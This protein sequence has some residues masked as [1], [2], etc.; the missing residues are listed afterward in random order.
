MKK[1]E[2]REI[3][4]ILFSFLVGALV[5]YLLL[6]ITSNINSSNII[7]DKSSIKVYEKTSL[8]SSLEKIYDAVVLIQALNGEEIKSNGSGFIYKVDDKYGYILTN[9]HILDTDKVRITFSDDE[10]TEATILGKDEYIDLAVLRIPK[11]YVKL[12]ATLGKSAEM[13]I[14]DAIYAVGSPLG[15]EYRGSVTSGILSG[16]NRMVST[17]ISSKKNN[18]WVMKVLQIDAS[19]N[20]GNS[21]GPILNINGE[22]IGICLMKLIEEDIE[23]MAFAIPIEDALNNIDD[24]EKGTKIKRPKLGINMVNTDNSGS[25]LN[26]DIELPK[27]DITGV[28]ITEIEKDTSAANSGLKKGDIITK[29]DDIEIKDVGYL[30]YEL[31]NHK[32]GD[33]INITYIRDNNVHQTKIKLQ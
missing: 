26:H 20:P 9:E 32:I 1:T 11:K 18:D 12:V 3:K 27:E 29:I 14:G 22:V 2:K 6:L 25:L 17:E 33:T 19:I 13:K 30:K 28:V 7:K 23:G 31:Y 16:K 5:M 21:G 4:I 8:S 10:Q 15:Y 24:L